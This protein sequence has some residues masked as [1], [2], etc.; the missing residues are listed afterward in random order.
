MNTTQNSLLNLVQLSICSS[1]DTITSLYDGIVIYTY[2]KNKKP[3][4]QRNTNTKI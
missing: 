3:V 2:K 1:G 4:D